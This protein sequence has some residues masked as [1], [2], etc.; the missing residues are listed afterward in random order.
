M[1]I[2]SIGG[3]SIVNRRHLFS[4]YNPD[5]YLDGVAKALMGIFVVGAGLVVYNTTHLDTER[6]GSVE[7]VYHQPQST[8]TVV[9]IHQQDGRVDVFDSQN[10]IVNK[11]MVGRNI[12]YQT[13]DG[14]IKKATQ[15]L[16]CR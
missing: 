5:T 7:Y 10:N 2:H 11:E 14:E 3:K 6:C 13:N 15:K 4:Q 16:R 8:N 12:S 9:Y 1:I